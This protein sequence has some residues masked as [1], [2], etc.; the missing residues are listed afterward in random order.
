[1]CVAIG[2]N[3]LAVLHEFLFARDLA[4]G[5]DQRR[6]LFV[7]SLLGE[8][9]PGDVRPLWNDEDVGRRQRMEVVEGEHLLV[10]IDGVRRNLSAQDSREDIAVVIRCCRIDWHFTTP[11]DRAHPLVTTLRGW[12]TRPLPRV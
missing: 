2:D 4:D 6:D 11:L 8:I 9:V 12:P 10:L 1:M 5:A 7:R 3:S